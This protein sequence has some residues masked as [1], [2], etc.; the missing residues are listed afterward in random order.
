MAK[1][2]FLNRKERQKIFDSLEECY[3]FSDS[4]IFDKYEILS[5]EKDD[6]S[7]KI[8]ILSKSVV[9][10]DFQ[11]LRIDS[12]GLYFG[13][14]KKG[15]F[16]LSIDGSHLIGKY[17]SKNVI[18]LDRDQLNK[19]IS[20]EDVDFEYENSFV[21]VRSGSDYFGSARIKDNVIFNHMPKER[22]VSSIIKSSEDEDENYLDI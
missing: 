11:N 10:L 1:L 20:G 6:D 22:R 16:R 17:C 8:F 3:G 15:Q 2:I 13:E 12:M 9:E 18:D 5:K 7:E 4:S 21:L 14:F 19:Y